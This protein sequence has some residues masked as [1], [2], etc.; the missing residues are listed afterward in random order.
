MM[1]ISGV[2]LLTAVHNLRITIAHSSIYLNVSVNAMYVTSV[3]APLW[4][5][6]AP[7][8]GVTISAF[9]GT[10]QDSNVSIAV[11]IS[12]ASS[13][14]QNVVAIAA[15]G[16]LQ[17]TGNV[18]RVAIQV[19]NSTL[20]LSMKS[21][22]HPNVTYS[23]AN[24]AIFYMRSAQQG[25][26]TAAVLQGVALTSSGG[27]RFFVHVEAPSTSND[28]ISVWSLRF[29]VMRDIVVDL[30]R[31]TVASIDTVCGGDECRTTL[32]S[33][34]P[35]A[36]IVEIEGASIA[37]NHSIRAHGCTF[38]INSPKEALAFTWQNCQRLSSAS[39]DV[40]DSSFH[41]ANTRMMFFG[42][43]RSQALV[44]LSG[45]DNASQVIVNV[46]QAS[47]FSV[48]E[49][50]GCQ[51]A[52]SCVVQ[53][54]DNVS[55]STVRISNATL[56]SAVAN[57]TSINVT[58]YFLSLTTLTMSTTILTI[59]M[60]VPTYVN[61]GTQL[62]V[63]IVNAT[64][65]AMHATTLPAASTVILV[66]SVMS[67]VNVVR[68]L[69]NCTMVVDSSHVRR[70]FVT[71]SSSSVAFE[72][73]GS[74]STQGANLTVTS[75]VNLFDALSTAFG[76]NQD[77]APFIAI[78]FSKTGGFAPPVAI[79]ARTS[80]LIA[81]NCTVS[82][83][84]SDAVIPLDASNLV[85]LVMLP[86]VS[87]GSTYTI[88]DSSFPL[89]TST[90]TI[91]SGVIASV[92]RSRLIDSVVNVSQIH[93][94]FSTLLFATFAPLSWEG[95][96]ATMV[97]DNV[98]LRSSESDSQSSSNT[99]IEMQ[100]S[101]IGGIAGGSFEARLLLSG[102]PAVLSTASSSLLV[103]TRCNFEGFSLLLMPPTVD[104]TIQQLPTSTPTTTHPLLL[105]LGCNVWNGIGLP[106]EA[107][108]TNQTLLPY[109]QYPRGAYNDSIHCRGFIEF[110]TA[111]HSF[112]HELPE[113]VTP[114]PV[115]APVTVS[116][117]TSV[118]GAAG[119]LA[120]ASSALVDAQGLVALGRSV[121]APQALHEA[122]S[123]SQFLLSPFY[124][125]GDYA[126]VFG[127]L[128]LF[129]LFHAVH[130][131][132]LLRAR[133]MFEQ[134][135]SLFA[136]N[137]KAL[138]PQPEVS[139]KY[140]NHSIT[141]AMFLAP[142]IVSG[143]V[144]GAFSGELIDT[145]A[146][147]V[148]LIAT[149]LG[150]F[151]RLRLGRSRQAQ[152]M[153]FEH[154]PHRVRQSFIASW[155][156]PYGQWG[157]F[158]LR[159]THGRLRGAV[160]GGAEWLS[161]QIITVGLLVQ[162]IASIPVP[163]SWCVGL[164]FV[165]CG[166]QLASVVLTVVVRPART[167][168]TDVVQVLGQLIIIALEIVAGLIASHVITELHADLTLAALSLAS[169]TMSVVK[170]AHTALIFMWERKQSPGAIEDIAVGAEDST[171]DCNFGSQNNR[172]V[173][174]PQPSN[175]GG[176]E[177]ATLPSLFLIAQKTTCSN[178]AAGSE[179]SSGLVHSTTASTSVVLA[180]QTAM[181]RALLTIITRNKKS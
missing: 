125:L 127:N 123:A 168:A 140:P 154:W 42:A 173:A 14:Y 38:S 89:S 90:T 103:I 108:T 78:V 70:T 1:D 53:L 88:R 33:N 135:L 20:T 177:S 64:I 119:V 170:A 99:I 80:T 69:E 26:S 44:D 100:Q 15:L 75:I 83:Q 95:T 52:A 152:R 65:D 10:I 176:I 98:S 79:H 106:T 148:A 155:L 153:R 134:T 8:N 71:P 117:V 5:L 61:A 85:A 167:P 180:N 4:Y 141:V 34:Y 136:V 47:V 149:V 24:P 86:G 57:G 87:N 158:S 145:V 68:F 174:D 115:V 124:S 146:G 130:R 150:V 178:A 60:Q 37:S 139:V 74:L 22:A 120:A 122:T 67:V 104:I 159:S 81:N 30:Q 77:L 109:I 116:T 105:R 175:D 2:Y 160:R 49:S 132:M 76:I 133:T 32:A 157:P 147:G 102:D 45:N 19:V 12:G 166:I 142:G 107:V 27:S 54:L 31:N 56:N 73:A 129:L 16:T 138:S 50:G 51:A 113:H 181:L 9:N 128:G 28:I 43:T 6:M 21:A 17:Y 41:A 118:A 164:W 94:G 97:F 11:N 48:V 96:H 172:N 84:H 55:F 91:G 143:G 131:L 23:A 165:L 63:T 169:M 144:R 111:S 29:A 171:D 36:R 62:S 121:C 151:L 46:D 3:V 39:A 179:R 40:T 163:T 156:L 58:K 112:T 161:A 137:S 93:Y 18:L 72:T 114:P 35:S 13:A 7:A 25:S 110:T 162:A 59:G 82:V 101:V 126:M 66:V 92:G